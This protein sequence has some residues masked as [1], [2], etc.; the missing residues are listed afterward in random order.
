ME[1]REEMQH[2][3]LEEG[4]D[5]RRLMDDEWGHWRRCEEGVHGRIEHTNESAVNTCTNF[6]DISA[7]N[8]ELRPPMLE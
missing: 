7:L 6:W 8:I 4:G 1:T 3:L 2:K 5:G